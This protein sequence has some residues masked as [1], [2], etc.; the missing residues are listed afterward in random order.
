MSF[1]D[2]TRVSTCPGVGGLRRVQID[3]K[4]ATR[5][6]LARVMVRQDITKWE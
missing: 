5:G 6:A 1:F 4:N 3:P 2:G